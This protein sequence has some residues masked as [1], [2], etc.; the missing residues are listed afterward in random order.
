MFLQKSVTT[1][2]KTGQHSLKT[3][4][5]FWQHFSLLPNLAKFGQATNHSHS[6]TE[7][8]AASVGVTAAATTL[9]VNFSEEGATSVPV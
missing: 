3:L 2:P 5:T 8:S 9:T 1:Q 4:Q 7:S 6:Y